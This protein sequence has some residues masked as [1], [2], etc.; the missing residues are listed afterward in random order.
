MKIGIDCRMYSIHFTGIGRYV[1]ELVSYLEKN[2]L[3]NEYVLFFNEPN[4]SDYIP[5]NERFKKVLVNARHYSYKEQFVFLYKLYKENLDLMHFTHF[6]APIFYKR[7]SVV[8]I[9]DLT[10]SFYP[11]KKLTKPHHRLAYNLTVKNIT[12]RAEKI[13]A[14]TKHTKK[15]LIEVLNVPEDKIEVIYE[16]LNKNDFFIAGKEDIE[17]LKM[18]FDLKKDYI[19]Y[20][21][22]LREHKNLLR[23]I[24]A[25]NELLKEGVIDLDLVI[26][27]K[28]DVYFEIRNTIINEGLQ[29]NVRLLGF[30]QE[31]DLNILYSGA[32]AVAYPSLYEGFGL[33]ILEAMAH[34]VP[35]AC[36]NFSCLPEIAGKDGAI[37]FNP[38][39]IESIK[40]SLKEVL[41][42]EELREKL[43]EN[44]LKRVDDFSWEKMGGEILALYNSLK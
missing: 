21:G 10:I 37:F 28:E 13:I 42:N 15:D 9:H 24:T 3:E 36:S 12:K 11:G 27:G 20:V 29:K 14:V 16:G 44:G 5:P 6:N 17:K 32:K 1:Y 25:Y 34:K 19:F 8:T 7:P 41:T 23:L 39:S 31:Q 30:V 18:K 2:D 22:V 38:L 35:L 26:A 40:N 43:I 33:P 4:F